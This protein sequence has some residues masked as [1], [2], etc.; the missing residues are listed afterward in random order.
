MNE[1]PCEYVQDSFIEF[2]LGMSQDCIINPLFDEQTIELY[3]K[4]YY[5]YRKVYYEILSK[6]I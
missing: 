2:S 4:V 1:I 6:D 5:A 3:S